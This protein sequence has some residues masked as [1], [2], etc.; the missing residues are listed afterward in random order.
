MP[1]SNP[2][3]DH[4]SRASCH[5]VRTDIMLAL[6]AV[7]EKHGITIEYGNGSFNPTTYNLRLAMSAT[8]AGSN[9]DPIHVREFKANC[10]LYG[11]AGADLGR[12]FLCNGR[13]F[14]V[15]GLKPSSRRY[16]ILGE[17]NGKLYKFDAAMVREL[18]KSQGRP[19]PKEPTEQTSLN[20]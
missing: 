6:A 1:Q 14:T 9:K 10:A 5:V 12:A 20:V 17:R 4:F 15:A 16:P 11:F 19:Q 2:R 13:G 8:P 3:I 18:L 7:A